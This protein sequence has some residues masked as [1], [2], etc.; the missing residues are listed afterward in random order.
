MFMDE[1]SMM[2]SLQGDKS[3]ESYHYIIKLVYFNMH[4]NS[5]IY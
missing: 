4:Q 2:S 3:Q 1:I 5:F